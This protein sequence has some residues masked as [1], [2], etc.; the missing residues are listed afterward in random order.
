MKMRY[1][2]FYQLMVGFLVVILVLMGITSASLLHFGRTQILH[3][4][5]ESFIHYG[6]LIRDAELNTEKLE[7]YH[8]VLNR[9]DINYAIFD[10]DAQLRYP[11]MEE[12]QQV[13]LNEEEKGKLRNGENVL[14]HMGT[15]DLKGQANETAALYLPIIEDNGKY[16]GFIGVERPLSEIELNIDELKRNIFKAFLLATVFAI[17][18]S[19]IFSYFM[20]KR[21]NRLSKASQKVATGDYDVYVDH[22]NRDEIDRLSADFN[23][24]VKALKKWRKEVSHLEK[25]RRTFMQ[26]AVHEMR[27]PLTTINGLIEGL[28]HGVFDEEQEMR[29]I[30][31]M[32]KETKRLIRLVNENLDYENIE[33]NRIF[34]QKQHFPLVDALAEISEQMEGKVSEA[35][36]KIIIQE[37]TEEISV[38]ADFD[39]FKQIMVNLL[40]N[41]NQFTENGKI[42]I[43]A[44]ESKEFVSI[45]I[46]DTGI[47]MSKEEM[48][49][50]WDRYYK[51]DPSRKNTKYGESGLGLAIVSKLIDLHDGEIKVESEEGHGS[52]FTLNFPKKRKRNKK[53][54]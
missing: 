14:L 3:E 46:K 37:Q 10:Q 4:V 20:V 40:K 6:E 15:T 9:K 11:E 45:R 49:N 5:E 51:A 18:I 22:S 8:Q 12:E 32:S 54:Q 13:E 34:L 28:E 1:P 23:K 44:D 52:Q 21:V 50:I 42:I 30:K 41:A 17:L 31:I 26:D 25:K 39:R 27:T 38:Y 7:A 36:N 47:G 33:S 16:R 2:F 48:K 35:N 43:D 19:M 24:M 53:D 29:S